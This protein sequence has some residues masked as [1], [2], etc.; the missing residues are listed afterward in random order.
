ML[1]ARRVCADWTRQR[2]L[3][4]ENCTQQVDT[5]EGVQATMQR[6]RAS[7]A[8][9]GTT[10]S[11]KNAQHNRTGAFMLDRVQRRSADTA[12]SEHTFGRLQ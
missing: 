9:T 6:L 4:A 5:G 8:P 3:H 1:P 11:A 10:L 7:R 2:T 12:I